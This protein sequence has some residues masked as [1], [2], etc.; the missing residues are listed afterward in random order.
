[1]KLQGTLD[2]LWIITI[3]FFAFGFI[4]ISF[5]LLGLICMGLPF[6]LFART[7][8]KIWCKHYCPRASLF[9]KVLNR[10]SLKKKLPKGFTGQ[11]VK[12]GVLV[13]FGVNLFFAMMSTIMVSLGRV[14]PLDYLRFFIVFPVPFQMPQ[15][16]DLSVSA[17]LLHFSYR[18]YSMMMTSTTIGLILGFLYVPRTWCVICPIQTLTT[19]KRA[20]NAE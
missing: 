10:I 8:E 7:K 18:I 17:G 12:Q 2:Y 16:L 14:A 15:L 9:M 1:M 6:I 4:H 13:Y 19:V 3:L 11:R 5:S 20:P